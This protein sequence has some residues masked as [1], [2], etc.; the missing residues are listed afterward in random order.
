MNSKHRLVLMILLLL[1]LALF[2]FDAYELANERLYWFD[3][4]V[5]TFF[6]DLR[7]PL[8]NRIMKTVTF[9]GSLGFSIFLAFISFVIMLIKKIDIRK[10]VMP[11][12]ALLG[13]WAL[14]NGLK[15]FFA[16]P[17][18][19]LERLAEVTGFSFPSGHAVLSIT[20]LGILGYILWSELKSKQLR[21][22]SVIIAFLLILAIGISRVYL[23]VH[24]ASDIIAG[25]CVGG[26]WL[27]ACIRLAR[28]DTAKLE[29]DY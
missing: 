18:P 20:V 27:T 23:G 28:A 11:L 26:I 24:Y 16:R 10:A 1:L 5:F 2:A 3:Q 4:P 21:W 8:M 25:Y 9:V 15:L 12:V 6:Y 22:A 13:D 17:R 29:N 19:S 7:S 14:I